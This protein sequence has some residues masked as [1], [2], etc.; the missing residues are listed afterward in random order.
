MKLSMQFRGDTIIPSLLPQNLPQKAKEL[1]V[2][3]PV[4]D[5]RKHF[6]ILKGPFVS[7]VHGYPKLP[8]VGT[9]CLCDLPHTFHKQV[10]NVSKHVF[11]HPIVGNFELSPEDKHLLSGQSIGI[12]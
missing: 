7:I 1:G 9:N 2:S 3:Y 11:C 5:L 8:T 4:G 10:I 12:I 6:K